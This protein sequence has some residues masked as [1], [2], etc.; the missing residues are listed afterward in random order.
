MH[1]TN[2]PQIRANLQDSEARCCAQAQAFGVPLPTP[3]HTRNDS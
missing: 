3:T 2:F 1:R